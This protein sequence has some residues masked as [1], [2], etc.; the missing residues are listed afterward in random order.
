MLTLKKKGAIKLFAVSQIF[1]LLIFLFSFAFI[2][3]ESYVVS[4]QTKKGK[5]IDANLFSSL[6]G[7]VE[8]SPSDGATNSLEKVGAP[9]VPTKTNSKASSKFIGGGKEIAQSTKENIFGFKGNYPEGADAWEYTFEDGHAQAFKGDFTT[10]RNPD[11]TLTIKDGEFSK[12]ISEEQGNA[13]EATAKTA[14]AEKLGPYEGPLGITGGWGHL[15]QGVMTAVMVVGAIQMIGGLLGLEQELTNTLSVAAGGGIM[16]Y[17]GLQSLGP[18]GFGAVGSNN[19]FVANAGWIGL[20]AAAIIF[21]LLYKETSQKR[22]SFQ[23]LPWEAPVGGKNCETCNDDPFRPCSEYRCKSLGQSCE[24]VNAGTTE[25]KCV[26]VNSKDTLSPTITPW[27]EVLTEGHKYAK[28]D[29][30]PLSLGTKITRDGVSNGCL[31]AFTPLTFGFMTDEPAQCKVDIT[32]K[33]TFEE[34]QFLFGNNNFYIYN[35]SHTLSLP[36]PD[37]VKTE[38]PEVKYDGKYDM[39]IRCRDK[40]GNEN[41]DEYAIQFCVDP[42]PDN[43]PAKIVDTS[44]VSGSAVR[45]NV[46]SV[47]LQIYVNEPANC[48]WSKQDKDYDSMENMMTCATSLSH[49]NA[50]ELYTCSTNLTGIENSAENKFYFRCKDQPGKPE[51][52]RFTNVNSREFIL[53]GSQ[54]LNIIFV[55]P[56]GTV[57]DNT[58]TIPVELKITTDDG[59]DEGVALCSFSSS[60]NSN[61]FVLMSETEAV[62]HKQEL[63]LGT[64]NYKYY[65]RCVDLGGNAAQTNVSFKVV[66]DTLAPLITRAY[67]DSS[68]ESLKIVTNEDA[69]CVYSLNSCNYNFAEGL[70]FSYTN[71]SM[72]KNHYAAWKPNVAYYIKCKDDFGNEPLPNGCSLTISASAIA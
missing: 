34:M 8:D 37:S 29:T 48:K 32:H 51:K 40:N 56:N 49:I 71:P 20:G 38:A 65:L 10:I 17:Q 11:K 50:R 41:V 6:F 36:S 4:G 70:G 47:P 60:G 1:S 31:K 55:A 7:F 57:T 35:H 5:E 72:K 14:G 2:I 33:S 9:N 24:I 22:V 67:H 26:W 66:S 42:S 27:K 54:S 18:T 45:Y 30:R 15:A 3:S 61:D 25:E 16:I 64:G 13:F 39:Y 59:A 68:Q 44:I 23:C 46:G 63:N 19:F 21:V 43:T 52:D 53:R 28:H 69:S 62:E 12:T 58:Q